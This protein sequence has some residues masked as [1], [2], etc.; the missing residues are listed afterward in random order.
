ML[1]LGHDHVCDNLL[2]VRR[3][4][5]GHAVLQKAGE[6]LRR[7]RHQFRSRHD[8]QHQQL[9][10][11]HAVERLEQAVGRRHECGQRLAG[12]GL[13][14]EQDILAAEHHWQRPALNRREGRVLWRQG[15]HQGWV[16]VPPPEFQ[17][18]LDSPAGFRR[19]LRCFRGFRRRLQLTF[20]VLHAQTI[21]TPLY[22]GE[23][24]TAANT[25]AHGRPTHA[26]HD[27][28]QKLKREKCEMSC[29]W[30]RRCRRYCFPVEEGNRPRSRR[31]SAVRAP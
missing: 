11:H 5:D 21:M 2:G 19:R 24:R 27:D 28:T 9:R 3:G 14:L 31:A 20:H 23:A 4:L 12:A 25:H 26:L 13:R 7:L 10:G 22:T 17:D 1:R 8:N 30:R 18:G 16:Q 15:F 29:K 6:H